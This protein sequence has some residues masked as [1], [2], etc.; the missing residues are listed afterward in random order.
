MG[1]ETG[2]AVECLGWGEG[3]GGKGEGGKGGV[4]E[5]EEKGVSGQKMGTGI[6]KEIVY[7]GG[8][9]LFCVM[10]GDT[11]VEAVKA[12][13]ISRATKREMKA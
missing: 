11:K 2:S 13:R 1:C 5:G 9:L 4:E 12:L 8:L 10:A 6:E 7:G 3:G